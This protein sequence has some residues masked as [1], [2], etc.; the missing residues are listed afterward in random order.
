MPCP[1]TQQPDGNSN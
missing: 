1:G